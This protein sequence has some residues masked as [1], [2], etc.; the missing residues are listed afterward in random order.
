MEKGIATKTVIPDSY[1]LYPANRLRRA[2]T[3]VF[4]ISISSR[5]TDPD[6]FK[7]PASS[8]WKGSSP[9][10]KRGSTFPITGAPLGEDQ[11]SGLLL[12]LEGREDLFER[13]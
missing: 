12:Q 1:R 10:G 6:Y 7:K 4:C 3:R 2:A 8:T 11:E 13:P 5:E 9:N